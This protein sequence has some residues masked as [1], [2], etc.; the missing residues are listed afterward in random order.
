[1][2]NVT[3]WFIIS[4]ATTAVFIWAGMSLRAEQPQR[5]FVA[6]PPR[7]RSEIPDWRLIKLL[8]SIEWQWDL[9]RDLRRLRYIRTAIDE[10]RWWPEWAA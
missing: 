7:H 5:V 1:M 9:S 6:P 2:D 4:N 10:S 3:A 8:P